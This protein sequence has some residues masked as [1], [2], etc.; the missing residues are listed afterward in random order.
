MREGTDETLSSGEHSQKYEQIGEIRLRREL[1]FQLKA[2]RN[3]EERVEELEANLKKSYSDNIN[4]AFFKYA[5]E[6]VPYDS[7]FWERKFVGR[8]IFEEEEEDMEGTVILDESVLMEEEGG[9]LKIRLEEEREKQ[10][11]SNLM[12]GWR[13]GNYTTGSLKAALDKFIREK[14]HLFLSDCRN[15]CFES[16]IREQR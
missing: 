10:I 2:T 13:E 7:R 11:V 14:Q 9:V 16:Y 4:D 15:F 6:I 1:F 5:V 3:F 8:V 12:G